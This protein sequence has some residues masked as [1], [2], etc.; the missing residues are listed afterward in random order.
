VKQCLKVFLWTLWPILFFI[1]DLQ[2]QLLSSEMG[3]IIVT[4]QTDQAGQRIDRIR[5]WL[6]NDQQ[7][8]TLYPKKDEFVS[9]S[10]TPNE[11]TVVIT[12]LPAGHYRIEFLI[13]N[14]DHFFEEVPPRTIILNPGAVVKIDQTIRLHPFSYFPSASNELAFVI[15]SQQ[16]SLFPPENLFPPPFPLPGPYNAFPTPASKAT[17]SLISNKRV[18]WKLVLQNR[19]IYSGVGSVANISIPPGHH[20]SLLAEDITGYSFYTTPTVPFDVAP[21]QIINME[22]LY[23]RDT[24]YITLQGILPSQ[25]SSMSMTLY[26]TNPNQ[27]PQHILLTPQNG[28]IFWT[29]G[30]LPT[31]KYLLSYDIPNLS[32]P[33]NDQPFTLEKGHPLILQVPYL[34][35]KGSLEITSDSSQARFT[36]T[37]EGG[38]IIGEGKGYHYTFKDLNA[39][40]Y[41]L[42]FS[43][44]DPNLAPIH[45]SQEIF[46]NN[47]QTVHVKIEYRKWG[48]LIINSNGNFQLLLRSVRTSQD[49]VH[50]TITASTQQI[51]H[52]PEGHYTLTYY[53]LTDKQ[54]AAKTLDIN[55]RA[56]YPQTLSLPV[57]QPITPKKKERT[58]PQKRKSK[59]P[60]SAPPFKI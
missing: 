38:A 56:A 33:I 28:K 57:V 11:R 10:H 30:P 48:D 58:Q 36:L 47:N 12:H 32:Q 34:S 16:N 44:A 8:R 53:S 26:S 23:Q 17:F 59:N 46:V 27:A 29:S 24:S 6:I 9:N 19:L 54:I 14:T 7:E 18:S 52:L 49:V 50:E 35:H 31:G 41:V 43:S 15:P 5:F 40:R 45:S 4:Y 39:G 25:V 51:F 55:I 3:T 21:G 13:P 60:Y 2:G 37:A 42:Q 22:L 1:L 20:Y